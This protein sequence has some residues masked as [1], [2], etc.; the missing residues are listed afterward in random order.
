MEK[1]FREV[2]ADIKEGEVWVNDTAPISF[3]KLRPGGI[4]DF[5]KNVGINLNVKDGELIQ[6]VIDLYGEPSIKSL[7]YIGPHF[8]YV[9]NYTWNCKLKN[10]VATLTCRVKQGFNV[11][12]RHEYTEVYSK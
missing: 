9:V 4:L 2:I 12:T 10:K 11:I 8:E 6:G 1:T 3:I 7:A 5:N